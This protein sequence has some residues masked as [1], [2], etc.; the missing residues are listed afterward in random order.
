MLRYFKNYRTWGTTGHS[1]TCPEG[2]SDPGE[3]WDWEKMF[4]LMGVKQEF[5]NEYLRYLQDT[6]YNTVGNKER[7]ARK[8]GIIVESVEKI[9]ADLVGKPKDF[10]F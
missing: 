7:S 3:Q 5:Y 1:N 4:S 8:W 10:C 9:R 6:A 2:K